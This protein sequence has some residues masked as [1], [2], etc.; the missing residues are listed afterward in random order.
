MY[1][2]KF[3]SPVLMFIIVLT[4]ALAMVFFAVVPDAHAQE[5]TPPSTPVPEIVGGQP[6]TPGEW[7]WQVAL[8]NGTATGPNY[9]NDQFCGGSLIH[10]EW[11]LTAGHCVTDNAGNV[12]AAS[13]IDIVA[14]IYN[15]SSPTA[16]YQQRNVTQIIRHPSY[17]DSTLDNDIALLK[18]ASPVTIGGS[19]ATTTALVPLAPSSIGSL[20]GVN[21]WATGWG[22]TESIP[23]FPNELYEVQ[24][25]IIANSVCNNASHYNGEITGNM[26]C[27]GYDAGGFDSCQGD[28]GG[29][30]VV[31]DGGVWKLAGVVSWGYGCADPYK[32]GVYA[33]VS[34]YG[35][36]IN[37][38]IG[39]ATLV[40][41]SGAI[42]STYNPTYTWNAVPTMTWYYLWVNGPS[43]N[44]IHEWFSA[45]QAGCASGTGTCS[46]IPTT[47]LGG[48]THTWWIQTWNPAG[49]GPWSSGMTF[50]TT[51]PTAPGA[52][53]LIAPSGAI[54]NYTPSF[55]W[56]E[57]VARDGEESAATWYN[58]YVNGPSGN[59]IN[60]WF[61]AASICSGGSCTASPGVT[62]SG[63][64]YSW[65]VQTWN[66]A[67]YGPWSAAGNFSLPVPTAPGAATLTAPSGAIANNTPSYTWSEVVARGEEESAA[68]WYYLWVDG[69]SGNVIRQW[70][71]ASA[72]CSGGTCSVTPSITLAPGNHIWYVQTW[73]SAG[74]GPWSAGK[75]FST[76]IPWPGKPT[77][78]SPSGSTTDLTPTYTWNEVTSR[79]EGAAT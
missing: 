31:Q 46:V 60:R 21:S 7:P 27:A 15:L 29:P 54:A 6:S 52:A 53:T 42:G 20:A 73:N 4:V 17:N 48:G 24:L 43:G 40:G 50:S 26:M 13:T 66:S 23:A 65:W 58:L 44:V 22:N 68:T 34:Q 61:E 74:Y 56:N 11:V 39:L 3:A 70:Y 8:V 72:V 28:S 67:G 10:P 25:P 1:T 77:L 63:G 12:Q 55:T 2:R 37:Q 79:T 69:P 38:N 5:G 47:P 71:E 49:F 16:G 30:L 36:W 78:S 51:I 75:S 62:L 41:P 57:V 19:G 59:V 45:E 64:S 35:A 14:G 33:R 18:L 32:P 9:Y 76:P